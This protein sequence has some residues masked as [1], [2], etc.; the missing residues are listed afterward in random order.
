M[1]REQRIERSAV[2]DK[3]S[4]PVDRELYEAIAAVAKKD[5]VPVEEAVASALWGGISRER[6]LRGSVVPQQVTVEMVEDVRALAAKAAYEATVARY[7]A[8]SLL[9]DLH[10]SQPGK[11]REQIKERIRFLVES[12]QQKA[13][14]EL[15]GQAGPDPNESWGIEGL[16][17]A[18]AF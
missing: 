16:D 11:T 7:L 1:S 8:G 12:A 2:H 17:T 6:P 18:P 15:P 10:A 14:Q 5:G 4:V 9:G 13:R 3:V